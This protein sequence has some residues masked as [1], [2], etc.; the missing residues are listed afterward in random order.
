[1]NDPAVNFYDV[2]QSYNRI[3]QKK[4][5]EIQRE[6]FKEL[7]KAKRKNKAF[8]EEE[9][10]EG[11]IPGWL[12][13]K[14]WEDYVAPRVYPSGDRSVITNGWIN[15]L[16]DLQNGPLQ[17]T[18]QAAN[19]SFM[20]PSTIPTSGG[21]AGRIN[22]VRF[23]PTNTSIM[24]VGSP[25]GGFWKSTN[26]GTSWN[27]TTD[28]LPVV[29]CTDLAINSNNGQI[30]YMAT[31]DGE[32][33]DTY[34]IGVYK[35]IDGGNTWN[36][37]GLNWAVTLN[38]TISRLLINPTNPNTIFAA[39]SLGV[40]RSINAGTTWTQTST[41]S[42]L[43]DIE[44]KPGDTTVIY[45]TSATRY[46]RSTNGG[47]S[48][49][50]ITSGLPANTAVN[51][52]AIGVTANDAN[53]VYILASNT[54]TS[55]YN[56]IYLS[57]DGGTTFTVK[58]TSPN[59]LGYSSI[60]NDSDGQGWY[61]LS[62]AVSPTNKLE[63]IV[64]GVNIWRSVNGGTSF[65]LSA[66]W[67][68]NAAAYVHADIHA[69]EYLPGSGT[70]FFAG[71][72]GGI[73]KTTNSG[74]AYSDLSSGL[75]I[76][77]M[78]RLG[79][80]QTNNNLTLTGWQDNGT[81][82]YTG[83]AWSR[84]LGGDGM[85]AII[86]WSNTNVQYGELQY[87][88]INRTTT[89][90]GLN[91]NIV[92]SGGTGVDADGA[93]VTPYIMN[94]QK[95]NTLLVGK[96]QVYKSVNRG[97]AWTQLGSITLTTSSP[98]LKSMAYAPSD[99]N[100]IYVASNNKFF[101]S[102]NG[103]SFTDRTTGL[104]V[105]SASITYIA[106]SSVDP[107]K[108]WVTFSGYSATIKVYYSANAG[109][110]WT[111]YTASGLPNLPVNCIVYQNGVSNDAL[112]VGTDVGVYYRDNTQAA[113][114]S[115][116]TGLPNV[117][118]N[119]LE[120]QYNSGKLRAATFGRGLWQSD[121]ISSVA[122]NVNIAISGTTTTIC[123]GATATFTAT[124]T[125]GG[126][127]PIYQWQVNGVNAGTNSP[128]FTSNTLINGQV[129]TCIMTSNLAGASN[130]PA[131]SNAITVIVNPSVVPTATI[132]NTSGNT[133]IC[134]GTNTT[135]TVT[136]TNGGNTPS[137]QWKVD[138][139]NAASTSNF[140]TTTSLT[141]G[142][143]VSCVITSNA[144]CAVPASVSS[145]SI[146]VTVSTPV[147]PTVNITTP[148]ITICTGSAITF[149]AATTNG[150]SAPNYQWQV[151]GVNAGTNNASFTANSLTNGQTVNCIIT[152]NAACITSNSANSNT[153]TIAV[154]SAVAPTI[155]IAPSTTFPLCS[156]TSATFTSTAT[157]GGNNP[158][159]QWL[160]NGVSVG[161]NSSSFASSTLPNG[162]IVAC[163]LTSNSSCAN[164]LS[165]F[166]NSV[167]ATINPTPTITVNSSSICEGQTA[168]II[169]SPSIN[170][171]NFL[172]APGGATAQQISV[173]PT[174]TSNYNVLYSLNNCTA[175]AIASIT[176]TQIPTTPT[177]SA[178]GLILTS[179]AVS[180]NQWYFNGVAISG[181]TGQTHTATQNGFYTVIVTINGC[182][183]A[184]STIINV[185]GVG[186]DELNMEQSFTIYPNPSDGNFTLLFVSFQKANYAIEI[187]NV[188]G[189]LIYQFNAENIKGEFRK[190]LSVKEYGK[191]V[192]FVAI[193]NK[194]LAVAKKIVVY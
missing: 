88:K 110:T 145:N 41:V 77:Q 18:I 159:Y 79:V 165:V 149:T 180:G 78:Y 8:E 22:F 186:I 55:D 124:P 170:G 31:G 158:N 139:V 73:F 172:W 44:Y 192:Y 39:T 59:L 181:A 67:T 187:R 53:Y 58:S 117:I 167:T 194:E 45:L 189:Q 70:T 127:T 171:G 36:T 178:N 83:A 112:Y 182:A 24:Y 129:V 184:S 64:G 176:V 162:A 10:S 156:G 102:T 90:G 136:T 35:S 6:Q 150:G 1:M 146:I 97:G 166:S 40:F 174:N 30:M 43:K 23:D 105:S 61:D 19:W 168:T 185:T 148:S 89:G 52:L 25:S 11:K 57:T 66:D 60:G 34:S 37:T 72:D 48:F 177:I 106:V 113:W 140:F 157:N 147:V 86:D 121:L 125:N 38:R 164:P 155:A 4:E 68:G 5:R 16:N 51:R 99:S 115:Y 7:Q 190:P 65:T 183:S 98:N 138:G 71:C 141:N 116:S 160:V 169:A 93:W 46:Y 191:G 84:P 120:I 161:N 87:G 104:P 179:S 13:Y 2:Q 152:S 20:G 144:S 131:T 28:Q 132:S 56:G 63:V 119:E 135:F 173:S 17:P 21:G 107:Q 49:T 33:S 134:V 62:I 12:L 175:S 75:Q 143:I 101:A 50:N 137:Y 14:R 95:A 94:P 26:G 130:N 103:S 74:N 108:V 47:T 15:Y 32:A 114:A 151:N 91:T 111:N 123:A 9:E 82:R 100:Y 163:M 81:N 85:E 80:A 142:Q 118:V 153:L 193:K 42:N 128:T 96:A 3:Y 154:V 92:A 76:A 188:L 69:L 27:T 122:A 54:T 126:S 29:G 109:V 133:T